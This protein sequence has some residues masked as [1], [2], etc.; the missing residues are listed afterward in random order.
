MVPSSTAAAGWRGSESVAAATASCPLSS[1]SHAMN[2]LVRP[3]VPS[4]LT[5]AARTSVGRERGMGAAYTGSAAD[6]AVPFRVKWTGAP[7]SSGSS[8]SVR[9]W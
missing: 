8:A 2:G 6:G 3:S 7:G 4:S 5:I 1:R 9:S